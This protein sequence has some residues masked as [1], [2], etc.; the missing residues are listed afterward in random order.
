MEILV[1]GA[2]VLGSLYA[3]FL[4]ESGQ[5]VWLLAREQ[6]LTDLRQCGIIL[7]DSATGQRTVTHVNLADHLADCD[8]YDLVIV[9]MRQNQVAS[10]LPA[11]SANRRIPTILFMTNNAAGADELVKAV[12][13]ERVLLGFPNAGGMRQGAVVRYQI[14]K[15]QPISLGELDGQLTPRLAQIAQVFRTSSFQVTSCANMDAWLKTHVALVSPIANAL[16]LTGGDNFRLARTRDG[17]VLLVY[18]IREGFRVLRADGI[19]IT[20]ARYRI[21]E[22]IPEPL[23]VSGLRRL[24]NT[25]QANLVMAQHANAA[26]DEMKF[27]ADEFRCLV[28]QSGLATPAIDRLY[29]YIDP[30]MPPL[31]QGSAKIPMNTRS[32]W[33]G[34]AIL[35]ALALLNYWLK[36]QQP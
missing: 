6:R 33:A 15:S 17:L 25:E 4:K 22:W 12:G 2:G 36:K 8:Y 18:A 27:L 23:L 7:E 34:A 13:R 9:L 21:L 26:R 29:A 19:P 30:S 35:S 16:Y 1:Y 10:I 5:D 11:L 3:A 31:T 24:F 20:P 14:A 32:L 28:V